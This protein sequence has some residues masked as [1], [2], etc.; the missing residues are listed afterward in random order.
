MGERQ[1]DGLPGPAADSSAGKTEGA[2]CSLLLDRLEKALIEGRN[3]NACRRQLQDQ[4]HWRHMNREQMIRWAQLSQMAGLFDVTAGVYEQLHEADPGDAQAW[5]LHL[6]LLSFLNR[7]DDA[8]R[9]AA[10]AKQFLPSSR[11]EYWRNLHAGP[12]GRAGDAGEPDVESAAAGPFAQMRQR[13]EGIERFM[14]LFSG[15]ED[16]FARQW[17]DKSNDRQGYVPVRRPMEPADVTNHLEGRRTYGIYLLDSDA[18]ASV[19]VIDADL[20]TGFRKGGLS[21]DQAR[22][23]KREQ[24]YLFR[25][26]ADASREKG[27]AEP[28]VEFSGGKGFHFWFFFET[29][30]PA[31]QAREFARSVIG[32]I[33]RDLSFFSLEVFPK[34]GRLTGKGFGNLVK[35]PLGIHRTT[36]KRSFFPACT[37]RSVDAQLLFLKKVKQA[38]VGDLDHARKKSAAEKVRVHPGH[39]QWAEQYPELHQL[40]T[41]CPPMGRI[42][43][44]CRERQTLTAREE[45]IVYQTIG[46]L[47]RRKTLLHYLL[48]ASPDY[49]PHQVDYQISRLRGSPLGCKRIHSLLDYTGDY[50][51]FEQTDGYPH[52]LLHVEAYDQNQRPAAGE[53]IRNL[54]DAL[55][56]MRAAI[57]QVERFLNRQS[58]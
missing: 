38:G 21:K 24:A 3:E 13:Q 37:D 32:D 30:I 44:A 51:R 4:S 2:D 22:Q 56:N 7:N 23:V 42:I 20:K 14:A 19:A 54:S 8:A 31:A 18:H 46:F 48:A 17:A 15:R 5:E 16:A 40:E 34:Q 10:R 43:A 55:D 33:S 41:R 29:P 45:K 12:A 28:L 1:A 53:K 57:V 52:P 11:Y 27:P 35:L 39:R 58:E 25:R 6:E 9:V 36:G 50:C 26:I 49:N 47:N